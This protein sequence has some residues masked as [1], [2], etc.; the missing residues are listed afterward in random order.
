MKQALIYF[1]TVTILITYCQISDLMAKQNNISSLLAQQSLNSFPSLKQSESAPPVGP[2]PILLP[3][4]TA[5]ATSVQK[6]LNNLPAT[7]ATVQKISGQFIAGKVWISRGPAGET[8]VKAGILYQGNVVA[9][10]RFHPVT[11]RILPVGIHAHIYY[12]TSQVHEVIKGIKA[13]LTSIIHKLKILPAAE[14][15]EPEA[16]W[17]FPIVLGHIIVSHLKVY[18]DGI[19]IVPD[20]PANQ[21]MNYYAK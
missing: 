12:N 17:I 19:H 2:F 11:G 5:Q 7:V 20:Y 1:I 3:L 6:L 18:Y 21:E 14:F 16:S 8:E 9:V 4:N 13:R 10:L 15:R